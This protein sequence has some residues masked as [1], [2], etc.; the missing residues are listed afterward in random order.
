ELEVT[1]LGASGCLLVDALIESDGSRTALMTDESWQVE[2]NG[3]PTALSV[4]RKPWLDMNSPRVQWLTLNSLQVWRRPHPLPATNWLEDAP[5]DGT[6]LALVSDA[7]A[8]HGRI[9]W[10]RFVVPSGAVRMHLRLHGA[11]TVYLDGVEQQAVTH[12]SGTDVTVM[13][14]ALS[15]PTA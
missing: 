13:E 15:H 8:E 14:V 4:Q 9:E 2:R 3:R 7:R 11:A 12:S 10:L 1:D 6:V 5:P